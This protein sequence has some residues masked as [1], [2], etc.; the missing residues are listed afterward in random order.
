MK[1]RLAVLAGALLLLANV[2]VSTAMARVPAYQAFDY[3]DHYWQQYY[4]CQYSQSFIVGPT[5]SPTVAAI[6]GPYSDGSYIVTDKDGNVSIFHGP[7]PNP[8]PASDLYD[9]LDQVEALG[10]FSYGGD[11]T[12]FASPS[13]IV[14]S[15][16][17]DFSGYDSS[18]GGGFE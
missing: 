6:T 2:S 4:Y 14:G 3:C 16:D 18:P 7:D 12:N 9:V 1:R 10:G 13:D 15:N 11:P 17:S 8:V 5:S